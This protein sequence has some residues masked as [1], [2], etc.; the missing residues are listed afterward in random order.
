VTTLLHVDCVTRRFG[1]YTALNDAT[2]EIAEGQVHALI[3]PNGAGKTTLFNVVSGVLRPTSGRLSFQGVDYTGRRPDQVL[4]MGIARNF[5]QVRL[6]RGLSVLENVMSGAHARINRGLLGNTA[7]FLGFATAE[8]AAREK[9]RAMLDFVGMAGKGE[10]QPDNLTLV[11]QRR[12]EIARALASDPRLLL[13][14][15]PA[16]GMNPTELDQLSALI[17]RIRANGLTVL[18]VEHHMRLVMSI[19]DQVTVLSA[20]TIIA[21]GTPQ[22]IQRDPAVIA[23]YLGNGDE[24]AL[25]S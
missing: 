24:L 22:E 11:D 15:E 16:A 9:A 2:C 21:A 18:L 23:A 1:G 3:G 5:Q 14:D 20:G 17:R 25:H 10:M 13:L 8:K 12:L 7:E 4:T 6:V 19:S